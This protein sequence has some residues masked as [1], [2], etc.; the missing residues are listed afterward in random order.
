MVYLML[1]T[2]LLQ[3]NKTDKISGSKIYDCIIKSKHHYDLSDNY[4]A[5][6]NSCNENLNPMWTK[7]LSR[8]F[9]IRFR[10]RQPFLN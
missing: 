8:K 3:D 1:Q 7:N 2:F 10:I 4:V 9:S 6:T 5:D